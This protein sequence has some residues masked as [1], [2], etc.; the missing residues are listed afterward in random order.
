MNNRLIIDEIVCAC[1]YELFE[2]YETP[3]KRDD[4][5][6]DPHDYAAVIGFYGS[7]IR[8]AVGIG[9]DRTLVAQMFDAQGN[10]PHLVEDCIGEAANQLLGR[11]KNKLIAY[12]VT[13]G[14]ALP[15]VLRGLEVHIVKSATDVWPYR[16]TSRAGGLTV[17]FDA[18]MDPGFVLELQG[19]PDLLASREGE[20]TLF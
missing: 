2:Q 10:S 3:L 17:W 8:G 19:D 13:L 16:F 15:M 14:S 5:E 18:Y 12:G 4:R 1:A 11:M 7:S 6:L 20:L 9:L